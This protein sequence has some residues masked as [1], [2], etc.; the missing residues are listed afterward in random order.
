MRCR[1][2]LERAGLPRENQKLK[3]KKKATR[4]HTRRASRH[5][6]GRGVGGSAIRDVQAAAPDVAVFGHGCGGEGMSRVRGPFAW[7]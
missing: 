2:A 1:T 6:G 3:K 5:H 7:T 4:A